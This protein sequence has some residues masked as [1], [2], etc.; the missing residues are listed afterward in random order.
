MSALEIIEI[1]AATLR[2][3]ALVG[4]TAFVLSYGLFFKWQSTAA[5]RSIM[6]FVSGIVMLTFLSYLAS[7]L[8]DRLVYE[9]VKMFIML[10][11]FLASWGLLVTLWRGWLKRPPAGLEPDMVLVAPT[12]KEKRRMTNHDRILG[13]IRTFTPAAVGAFLAW[14]VS[15][16]P[17]VAEWLAGVDALLSQGDFGGATAQGILTA[18][19][20]GGFTALYYWLVRVLSP[21][22]PWL[23]ALLGSKK[24][25]VFMIQSEEEKVTETIEE[26]EDREVVETA[27]ESVIIANAEASHITHKSGYRS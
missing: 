16:I 4:A 24:T 27:G 8:D 19:A 20:I 22:W 9:V 3:L 6:G 23:E 13:T 2:N 12:V 18:L 17:A 25:P 26:H 14:L 11:V 10:Y 5:G 7:T 1:I 15:K 21:R